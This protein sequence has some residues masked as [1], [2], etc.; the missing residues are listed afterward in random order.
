MLH[1][2][3]SMPAVDAAGPQ[4]KSMCMFSTLTLTG[5]HMPES[6]TLSRRGTFPARQY[7]FQHS[8]LRNIPG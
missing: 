3:S 4:N 5:A 8:K 6:V 7:D 1:Y 2:T